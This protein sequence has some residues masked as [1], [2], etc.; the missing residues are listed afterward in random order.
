MTDAQ[1]RPYLIGLTGNIAC[2]K[3]TVLAQ[4]AEL[5]AEPIDADRLV[6]ELMTPGEPVW[7]AIRDQ[8]GPGVLTP[9]GTIDRRALGTIVFGDPAALARLEAITHPSVRA[10]IAERVADAAAR[11]TPVVVIDAI[12][13]LE[14]GLADQCDEV[15]VVTCRPE[16]QLARL[17]ARNGF[18]EA[19]A[20]QRI[21]AQTPQAAKM[22]R[23]DVVIDNSRTCEETRAQ[24]AVAWRA[25]GVGRGE[26]RTNGRDR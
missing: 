24:V 12:K 10:R 14:G 23:A 3:S 19:E 8:F 16:Q 5:G 2:G 25:R 20:R 9:A 15:W 11:G 7:A 18:D 21:E 1:G 17:M 6:H 13:L 4:L 22:A 26:W